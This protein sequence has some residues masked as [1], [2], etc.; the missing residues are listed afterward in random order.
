MTSEKARKSMAKEF[1]KHTSVEF[2]HFLTFKGCKL[3]ITFNLRIILTNLFFEPFKNVKSILKRVPKKAKRSTNADDKSKTGAFTKTQGA[4]LINE[5]KN[6][7]VTTKYRLG[8]RVIN[9]QFNINDFENKIQILFASKQ[10]CMVL[11]K[12]EYL[13]FDRFEQDPRIQIMTTFNKL[14]LFTVNPFINPENDIYW[15]ED[16]KSEP[17]IKDYSDC[18][19][20]S[21]A[22]INSNSE[23]EDISEYLNVEDIN[24]FVSDIVPPKATEGAIISEKNIHEFIRQG[25]LN[26]ISLCSE[27]SAKYTYYKLGECLIDFTK[28]VETSNIWTLIAGS[29]FR[30][31]WNGRLRMKKATVEVEHFTSV[32]N[33]QDFDLFTSMTTFLMNLVAIDSINSA[34]NIELEAKNRRLLEELKEKGPTELIKQLQRKIKEKIDSGHIGANITPLLS[35]KYRLRQ[36]ELKMTEGEKEVMRIHIYNCHGLNV[37]KKEGFGEIRFG[38]G[39][40]QIDNPN[41]E[42]GEGSLVLSRMDKPL[43]YDQYETVGSK[44]LHN[45]YENEALVISQ[46]YFNVPGA[47]VDG[48]VNIWKAVMHTEIIVAPLIVNVTKEIFIQLSEYFFAKENTKAESKIEEDI[49]FQQL[50]LENEELYLKLKAQRLKKLKNADIK[51]HKSKGTTKETETL[52]IPPTYYENITVNDLN[53]VVTFKS[54]KL[55]MVMCYLTNIEF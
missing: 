54:N 28:P 6:S 25:V 16:A 50:Y 9:P 22:D 38:I 29:R 42:Q 33:S 46:R 51:D 13:E 48:E 40:F 47:T 24:K 11:T 5:V 10:D 41:I 37:F 3:L 7:K 1:N 53:L 39:N 12:F 19:K 8:L 52:Q 27:V 34:R 44:L 26:R 2:E 21:S 4:S 15:I 49:E 32:M 17:L 14:E 45:Q 35:L 55:F 23:S 43:N 36:L 20:C 18:S 31:Y 30:N